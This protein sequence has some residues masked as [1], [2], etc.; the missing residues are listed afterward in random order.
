MLI[1]SK[2]TP[3]TMIPTKKMKEKKKKKLKIEKLFI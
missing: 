2:N 1:A 3:A